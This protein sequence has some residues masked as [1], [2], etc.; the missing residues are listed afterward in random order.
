MLSFHFFVK[1]F[2]LVLNINLIIKCNDETYKY[3]YVNVF[4]IYQ[5]I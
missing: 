5:V 2:Y 1:V 3:S 4:V